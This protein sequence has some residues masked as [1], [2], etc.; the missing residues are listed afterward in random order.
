MCKRCSTSVKMLKETKR[1]PHF[2]R[3]QPDFPNNS[4]NLSQGIKSSL[5]PPTPNYV[6]LKCQ[7]TKIAAIVKLFLG[8][9][10]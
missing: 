10:F 8:A 4:A 5:H 3:T 9:L 2:P 1:P 6:K 7:I